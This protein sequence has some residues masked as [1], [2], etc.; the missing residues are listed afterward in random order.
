MRPDNTV[1]NKR[2]FPHP[3]RG[4]GLLCTWSTEHNFRTFSLCKE[5]SSSW[6]RCKISPV[7]DE[8]FEHT[9]CPPVVVGMQIRG[10]SVG[11]VPI[12]VW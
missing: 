1:K 6:C 9:F 8:L 5:S 12:L 10:P 11:R 7:E 2:G 3:R 4:L